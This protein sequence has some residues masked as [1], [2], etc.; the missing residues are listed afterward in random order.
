MPDPE[1]YYG[2]LKSL[3][4]EELQKMDGG[5][6]PFDAASLADFWECRDCEKGTSL[7]VHLKRDG[8]YRDAGFDLSDHG[9]DRPGPV[10]GG[11]WQYKAGVLTWRDAKGQ[12]DPNPV[13][14]RGALGF[15][16]KEQDGSYTHFKRIRPLAGVEKILN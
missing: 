15:V 3:I 1:P 13:V 10:S 14:R 6:T 16:L 4:R 7:I 8:T 9:C 2:A 5:G 11:T 12:D